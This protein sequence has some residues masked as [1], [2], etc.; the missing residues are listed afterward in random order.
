[1]NE[2]KNTLLSSI[3]YELVIHQ[4]NMEPPNSAEESLESFRRQWQEEISSRGRQNNESEEIYEGFSLPE[5]HH[6]I[7]DESSNAENKATNLYLKGVKHEQ[8]G[9][10]VEAIRH[11]KQAIKL[12][13]NIE[14]LM[15]AARVAP[16]SSSNV[17][18]VAAKLGS[19]ALREDSNDNETN[20]NCDITDLFSKLVRIFE[21]DGQICTPFE[22]PKVKSFVK[23]VK[24][25][26]VKLSNSTLLLIC[27]PFCIISDDSHI[28]TTK[29]DNCCVVKVDHFYRPRF[30]FS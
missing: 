10:M 7:L 14:E 15:Y 21:E 9:D 28:I 4:G 25:W 16:V 11:Y 24:H 5:G 26:F 18:K 30:K 19:V 12:V 1:V 27:I 29:R 22:E 3:F 2:N 17:D 20:E 6:D 13:P 23:L 8:S